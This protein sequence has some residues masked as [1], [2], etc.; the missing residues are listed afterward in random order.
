V[1]SVAGSAA[2]RS[3]ARRHS[4]PQL[5]IHP[6]SRHPIRTWQDRTDTALLGRPP[7]CPADFS[8]RPRRRC[9]PRVRR[10]RCIRLSSAG[11]A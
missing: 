9:M 8:R 3:S 10:A 5:A 2:I 6:S 1:G 11:S 4:R 7:S